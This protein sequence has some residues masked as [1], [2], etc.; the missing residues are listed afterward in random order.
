MS[1]LPYMGVKVITDIVDGHVESAEEFMANLASAAKS[2]QDALP[3]VLDYV[4]DHKEL[5]SAEL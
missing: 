1:G 3:K 2:L 5:D 4:C